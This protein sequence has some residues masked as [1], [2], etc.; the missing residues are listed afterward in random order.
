MVALVEGLG[1]EVAPVSGASSNKVADAYAR[2]GKGA[3]VAALNFGDCFAY[4]LAHEGGRRLLYVAD[5]FAQTD[6]VA[7]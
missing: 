1:L 5:N 6:L 3:H 2:W 4:A 7:A